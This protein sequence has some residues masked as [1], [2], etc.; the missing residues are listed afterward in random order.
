MGETLGV[1]WAICPFVTMFVWRFKGGSGINGFFMGLLLGPVGAVIA[2]FTKP[3]PR[4]QPGEVRT[5]PNATKICEHCHE[6]MRRAASVCPHCHREAEPWTFHNQRWWVNRDSGDYW[7][8]E[9]SR[10]WMKRES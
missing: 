5:G 10:R 8:E 9:R 6:H 7:F 1:I 3:L 2:I 4:R